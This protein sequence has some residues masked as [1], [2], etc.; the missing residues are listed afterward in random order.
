MLYFYQIQFSMDKKLKMK[1]N[2][3]I[4]KLN[5]LY[6]EKIKELIKERKDIENNNTEESILKGIEKSI[7][8]KFVENIKERTKQ[9]IT[10]L[11]EMYK[12]DDDS[13]SKDEKNTNK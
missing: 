12:Y 9:M 11:C 4:Y 1:K 5:P 10:I 7:Y 6:T 2:K 8:D 13:K 3:E